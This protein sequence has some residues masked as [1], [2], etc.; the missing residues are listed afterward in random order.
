MQ[1]GGASPEAGK[2]ERMRLSSHLDV[3]AARWTGWRSHGRTGW[4]EEHAQV[5]S[6]GR[7][8]AQDGA[9]GP[10]RALGQLGHPPPSSSSGGGRRVGCRREVTSFGCYLEAGTPRS[11]GSGPWGVGMLFWDAINLWLRS[12][13]EET[14]RGKRWQRAAEFEKDQRVRDHVR[15]PP[16]GGGSREGSGSGARRGVGQGGIQ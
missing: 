7:A 14:S 15:C 13:G 9:E 11:L 1:R 8:C 10:L 16:W 2:L 5:G 6:A 12:L 3:G 4:I